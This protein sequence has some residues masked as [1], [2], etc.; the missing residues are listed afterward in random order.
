VKVKSLQ[1]KRF[2]LIRPFHTILETAVTSI[3]STQPGFSQENKHKVMDPGIMYNRINKQK[4]KAKHPTIT[5]MY[6]IAP[7]EPSLQPW[8]S[9]NLKQ[10]NEREKDLALVFQGR[11]QFEEENQRSGPSSGFFFLPLPSHDGR[12]RTAKLLP[13]GLSPS[14]SRKLP[15]ILPTVNWPPSRSRKKNS[16][17]HHRTAH[18]MRRL[19]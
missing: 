9:Q 1:L 8:F 11:N 19:F 3:P 18:R 14:A 7:C 13:T 15:H 17:R 4:W 2:K 6:I 16:M 10:T 12:R 5:Y